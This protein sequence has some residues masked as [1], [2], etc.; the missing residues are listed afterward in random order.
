MKATRAN[1][2]NKL[3]RSLKTLGSWLN[4]ELLP[5]GLAIA[6]PINLCCCQ[7]HSLYIHC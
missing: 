7:L 3:P 1:T 5:I 2:L 6:K 4:S